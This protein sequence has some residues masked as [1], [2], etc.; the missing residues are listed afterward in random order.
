MKKLCKNSSRF[1]G[2]RRLRDTSQQSHSSD[3][4]ENHI[5]ESIQKSRNTN[6]KVSFLEIEEKR[7]GFC[8]N[9]K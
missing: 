6:L 4:D 3:S 8:Y 1:K 5:G 9:L 7:A 2:V